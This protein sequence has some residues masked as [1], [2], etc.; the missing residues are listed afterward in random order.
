MHILHPISCFKI[1]HPGSHLVVC[2][3]EAKLK[4]KKILASEEEKKNV[5]LYHKKILT[6][7]DGLINK[8]GKYAAKNVASYILLTIKV[9]SAILIKYAFN[10][11]FVSRRSTC[12]PLLVCVCV[13][14]GLKSGVRTQPWIRNWKTNKVAWTKPRC[15]IP[16]N[17]QQGV[18]SSQSQ[19]RVKGGVGWDVCVI[20]LAMQ[21]HESG[22]RSFWREVCI[23]LAESICFFEFKDQRSFSRIADSAC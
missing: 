12:C 22:G 13:C 20:V 11:L 23:C 17:Q 9:Q 3:T 16:A 14:D 10:T 2:G 21:V 1:H 18:Y 19:C 15:T 8:Q 6:F 5:N 7:D 4:K